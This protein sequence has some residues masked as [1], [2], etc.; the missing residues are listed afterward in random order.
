LQQLLVIATGFINADE[1]EIG[2]W[3]AFTGDILSMT[4]FAY[5]GNNLINFS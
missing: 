1:P 5:Y 4:L 3:E 2:H